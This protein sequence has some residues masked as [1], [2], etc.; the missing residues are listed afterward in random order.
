[1]ILIQS[2]L[3][4]PYQGALQLGGQQLPDEEDKWDPNLSP[5]QPDSHVIPFLGM[6][7]PIIQR[8][9]MN[10]QDDIIVDCRFF[11]EQAVTDLANGEIGPKEE[12]KDGA[13]AIR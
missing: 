2:P 11:I 5:S 1:M 13:G 8:T 7:S 3:P 6:P 12:S 10:L 4:L 9:L